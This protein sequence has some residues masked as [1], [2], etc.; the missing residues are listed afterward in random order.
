[1]RRVTRRAGRALA[2]A[3]LEPA[4][5]R[6][7]VKWLTAAARS[8]VAEGGGAGA[9]AGGAGPPTSSSSS[10]ELRRALRPMLSR[11]QAREPLQYICGK[12]PF[13]GIELAVRPPVLVPR[14]ETEELAGLALRVLAARAAAGA[15]STGRAQTSPRRVD[16]A[17]DVGT[18]SGA[19]ALALA[20]LAPAGALAGGVL[21]VDCDAAAVA[22]A[23]ENVAAAAAARGGAGGAPAVTVLHARVEDLDSPG[24]L[25]A[26]L[27]APRGAEAGGHG[28]GER[29][30]SA[31]TLL[32]SNPPYLPFPPTQPEVAAW[33]APGALLGGAPRGFGAPLS[34][35][36]AAARLCVAGADVLLELDVEHPPA[37]AR[38]LLARPA[39]TGGEGGNGGA[40]PPPDTCTFPPAGGMGRAVAVDASRAAAGWLEDELPPAAVAA[41][42]QSFD[43]VGGYADFS[44]RPR[45]VHVRVREGALRA[46]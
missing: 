37:L 33:E 26:L 34:V 1:M 20:A 11:R 18:G 42:R 45:F 29:P 40:P 14:P 32:V 21:A 44:G 10:L 16:A 8:L 46:P 5:A 39:P 35:L 12:W 15:A 27:A 38:L 19:L 7:S 30:P 43:F 9:L 28:G 6:A 4:D 2:R 25:L 23:R 31:F 24:P 3:G 22:L 13:C 36:L 17:L 41:L